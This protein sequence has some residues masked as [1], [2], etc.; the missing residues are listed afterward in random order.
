MLRGYVTIVGV[1]LLGLGAGGLLGFWDV[2]PTEE[3]LYPD[4]FLYLITGFIFSYLGLS[5]KTSTADIR[6]VVV[7]MG[8][9]YA[10]VGLLLAIGLPL[11]GLSFGV[12]GVVYNLGQMTFGLL[13]LIVGWFLS[14]QT[15]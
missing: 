5:P 14:P 1:V 4:D 3:P 10:L 6:T 9:L 11:L 12:Y 15:T 7:G 8:V 13:N 2:T